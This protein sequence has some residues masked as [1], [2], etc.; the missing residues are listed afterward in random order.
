MY[1]LFLIS[2]AFLDILLIC[3]LITYHFRFV[4]LL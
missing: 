4:Q 2:H 3:I 1:F